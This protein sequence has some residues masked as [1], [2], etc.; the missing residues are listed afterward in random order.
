MTQKTS[1]DSSPTSE[2]TTAVEVYEP[3]V[4]ASAIHH[5]DSIELVVETPD[6]AEHAAELLLNIR[7]QKTERDEQLGRVI[8]PIRKGLDE[9]YR[10]RREMNANY[11]AA[12]ETVGKALLEY[13]DSRVKEI[14]PSVNGQDGPNIHELPAKLNVRNL[15]VPQPVASQHVRETW[16]AI[17]DDKNKLIAAVN[18]GAPGTTEDLLQVNQAEANR[19]ARELR[20]ELNRFDIGLKA[21]AERKMIVRKT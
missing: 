20:D 8:G 13:H 7:E 3:L 16:R 11:D 18:D 21:T 14:D 1:S 5:K 15:A 4:R 10:I 6:Q 12:I 19:L 17:V 2:I 9:L